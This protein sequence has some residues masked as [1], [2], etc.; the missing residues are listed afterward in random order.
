MARAKHPMFGDRRDGVDRR[1]QELPMPAALNRRSSIRRNRTFQAQPWWLQIDYAVE[2]VSEK[3]FP[4]KAGN[5][6]KKDRS[7]YPPIA[8]K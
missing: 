8:K 3:I 2:L 5:P 6:S 4:E 7:T 1:R